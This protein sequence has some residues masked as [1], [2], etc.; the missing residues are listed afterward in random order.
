[1]KKLILSLSLQL[2]IIAAFAQTDYGAL[3]MTITEKGNELPIPFVNVVVKDSNG[4]M[5]T[6][7]QSDFDGNVDIRPIP[8]GVYT[9]EISSLGFTTVKI[10]KVKIT[11]SEPLKLQNVEMEIINS[12]KQVVVI[13]L[14]ESETINVRGCRG[15]HY[16]VDYIKVRG[17]DIPSLGEKVELTTIFGGLSAQ[18]ANGND[19]SFDF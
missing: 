1:M 8:K 12:S 3:T 15:D 11:A 10:T 18:Y 5:V 6:G 16:Y 14:P 7:A 17:T 19:T 13:D 9:V 4:K 2:I